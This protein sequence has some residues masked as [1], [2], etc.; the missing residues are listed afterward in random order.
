MKKDSQ[1]TSQMLTRAILQ[2]VAGAVPFAGGLLSAA[3]SLSGEVEQNQTNALLQSLITSLENDFQDLAQTMS[4]INERV[5]FCEEKICK[6]V[7]SKEYQALFMKIIR[8]WSDVDTQRKR[9]QVRNLLVNAALCKSEKDDKIRQCISWILD[10]SEVEIKIL[11]I[12]RTSGENGMSR[13]QI[14]KALGNEEKPREVSRDA[15]FF[16]L[17]MRKLQ[18]EQLIRVKKKLEEDGRLIPKEYEKGDIEANKTF[19]DTIPFR[20]TNLGAEFLGFASEEI[21]EVA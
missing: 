3:I 9:V 2:T 20:L 21:V 1:I 7:Q 19:D 14:W 12:I 15:D 17:T 5:N 18:N 13:E 8:N 11:S 6:R 16:R 10:L 4:E